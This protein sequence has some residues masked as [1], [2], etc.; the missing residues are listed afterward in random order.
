MHRHEVCSLEIPATW[1][2]QEKAMAM[3][4]LRQKHAMLQGAYLN[5][6]NSTAQN[7][8]ARTKQIVLSRELSYRTLGIHVGTAT[9]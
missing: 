8:K 2:Y 6:I 3:S 9:Y 7:I 5:G 1:H 4:M